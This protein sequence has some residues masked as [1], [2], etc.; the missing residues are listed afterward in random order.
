MERFGEKPHNDS[1]KNEVHCW[2]WI[3]IKYEY[4]DLEDRLQK[5][6]I[7]QKKNSPIKHQKKANS[8]FYNV[9]VKHLHHNEM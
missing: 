4:S 3:S 5:Q 2:Q 9:Y 7:I 8:D 1:L 6:E